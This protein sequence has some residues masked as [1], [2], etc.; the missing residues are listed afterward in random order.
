MRQTLLEILNNYQLSKT[1][2]FEGNSLAKFLRSTV[3]ATVIQKAT[4]PGKYKIA[5]SAG[6][7]QWAEIPWICIFDRTIT[8]TAQR[9]YYIV[10]LFKA[11]M[12]GVF[13]SLNMGWTQFREK[14]HP[15]SQ[16]REA[17]NEVSDICKGLL[18]SKLADFS[19]RPIALSSKQELGIGYQLGHICGKYYPRT[20][21]PDDNLLIDDLRNM[22]GVYRELRGIL[23]TNDITYLPKNY[24]NQL[25]KQADSE[26]M[27]YQLDVSKAQPEDVPFTP[28]QKPGYDTLRGKKRWRIKPGIAKKVLTESNFLCEINPMQ[29]YTF[30][31]EVTGE[32]FV[33]A[34]HL[35][36]MA[37]QD[38]FT[39][40]L[41]IPA[42]SVS[43]CPNCH[44]LLHHATQVERIKIA[45]LLLENRKN[46]LYKMGISLTK[47]ELTK[48]Y[49]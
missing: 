17:I 35:I 10:Y 22:I 15:V 33:E 36:P 32:N 23:K 44:R 45:S 9:G 27:E 8:T 28:Q 41:D 30:K 13:L 19:E 7:G 1:Q 25:D 16:A 24:R 11:D 21:M 18:V 26:D 43:V 42:Y 34:H 39:W 37:F 40:S 38:E 46:A 2:P 5:G 6:Q 20:I 49:N 3:P 12:S 48:F 47:D 4:L 31:S 29:H 14:Y